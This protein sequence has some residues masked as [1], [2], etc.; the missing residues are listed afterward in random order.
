MNRRIRLDSLASLA[1]LALVLC[2]G[3]PWSRA[4]SQPAAEPMDPP[5]DAEPAED[6]LDADGEESSPPK[7][8]LAGEPVR[9][10]RSD[11]ET[12]TM[13][14]IRLR[15][16]EITLPE[17]FDENLLIR[18][19]PDGRIIRY[20]RPLPLVAFEMNP[21]ISEEQRAEL[22]PV[23]ERRVMMNEISAVNNVDLMIKIDQGAFEELD[24][25]DRRALG[26]A[27]RV[28]RLLRPGGMLSEWLHNQSFI[29]AEQAAA[30][31]VLGNSYAKALMNEMREL[32]GDD[33]HKLAIDV[34]RERYRSRVEES[35][36]AY[37]GLLRRAASMVDECLAAAAM[38][39]EI[40]SSMASEVQAVK[41]ARTDQEQRQAVT[42]LLLKMPDWVMQHRFL[43]RAIS[44]RYPDRSGKLADGRVVTPVM[45]YQVEVSRRREA[46]A[47]GRQVPYQA[48]PPRVR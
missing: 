17:G 24:P 46:E 23:L 12:G 38:P 30:S 4:W 28:Q 43:D 31:Q 2:L 39:G 20:D 37:H 18:R 35:L 29:T 10:P 36:H 6:G 26:W 40:H 8:R 41:D 13:I 44:E 32:A 27:E 11:G 15:N 19:G 5:A 16:G 25:R 42:A 48:E 33:R 45:A 3:S 1:G 47:A 22:A 9:S 7:A 14:M 21:L 34:T